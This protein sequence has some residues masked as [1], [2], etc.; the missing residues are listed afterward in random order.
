M[1]LIELKWFGN[2]GWY[3]SVL[4]CVLEKGLLFEMCGWEC[5]LV[6]FRLV[7]KNVMGLLVI[8]ELWLVCSV[9]WL[10]WMFCLCSVFLMSLCVS[11]LV[12]WCVII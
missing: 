12:L 4:N 10:G 3:F 9:S 7:Y 2:F 5:V 1:C 8:D 6:M 11:C